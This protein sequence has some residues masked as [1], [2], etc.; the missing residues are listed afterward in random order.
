MRRGR[1]VRALTRPRYASPAG[2]AGGCECAAA[3]LADARLNVG[4]KVE[5]EHVAART[6]GTS[7][8]TLIA[9]AKVARVDVDAARFV[10]SLGSAN[11]D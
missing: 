6:I 8:S 7:G 5:P 9:S 11:A 10:A 4:T 3:G 2:L 1:S